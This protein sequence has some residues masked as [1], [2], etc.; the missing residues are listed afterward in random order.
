MQDWVA[1]YSVLPMVGSRIS[2]VLGALG[3]S[4]IFPRGWGPC[5]RKKKGLGGIRRPWDLS[6]WAVVGAVPPREEDELYWGFLNHNRAD[7]ILFGRFGLICMY[8]SHLGWLLCGF[9]QRG[10]QGTTMFSGRAVVLSVVKSL[11]VVCA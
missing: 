7:V 1:V 4:G 8:I 9:E 2:G 5:H 11:Y 6:S 10:S 3:V